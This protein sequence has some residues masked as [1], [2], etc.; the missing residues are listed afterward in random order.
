MGLETGSASSALFILLFGI[1]SSSIYSEAKDWALG[2]VVRRA[3]TIAHEVERP[4]RCECFVNTSACQVTSEINVTSEKCDLAPAVNIQVSCS[5]G[6]LSF[7]LGWVAKAILG[8]RSGVVSD[9]RKGKGV[10]GSTFQLRD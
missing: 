1:F 2:S 4:C 5:V 6:F 8:R 7:V 3:A 10:R 9:F